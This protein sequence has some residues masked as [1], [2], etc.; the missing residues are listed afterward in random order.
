[1]LKLK[2]LHTLCCS[3]VVES[4]NSDCWF[5]RLKENNLDTIPNMFLVTWTTFKE[6]QNYTGIFSAKVYLLSYTIL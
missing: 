3:V 1:M 4:K 5:H 6:N 2:L